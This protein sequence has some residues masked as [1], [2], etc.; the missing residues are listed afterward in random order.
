MLA[1]THACVQHGILA[2]F[3]T[4]RSVAKC[5]LSALLQNAA[6]MYSHCALQVT[7]LSIRNWQDSTDEKKERSMYSRSSQDRY[8]SMQTYL[9]HIIFG[10]HD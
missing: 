7:Y 4:Q 5:L 3:L 10:I 6:G 9:H 1:C 8:V 2:A